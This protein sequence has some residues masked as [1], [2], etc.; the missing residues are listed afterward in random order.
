VVAD[1]SF[2][3]LALV[4]P[5]LAPLAKRDLLLLVKPQFE[6]SPA[7][8]GKGGL[9]RDPAAAAPIVEAKLRGAAVAAGLCVL[10]WFASPVEGG[11]GNREF[12]LHCTP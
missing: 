9:V 11:D 12:F 2:I 6:L 10:G 7:E 8:I 3:S 5:A 1:L 4:L